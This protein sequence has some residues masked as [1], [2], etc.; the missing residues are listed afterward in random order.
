MRQANHA[1][2]ID[3]TSGRFR[4][5]TQVCLD[6]AYM[7]ARITS[8]CGAIYRKHEITQTQYHV[9]RI[10]AEAGEAGMPLIGVASQLPTRAA[11]NTRVIE[12]MRR[13]R[14]VRHWRLESDRRIVM[15]SLSGRGERMLKRIEPQLEQVY[16]EHLAHMEPEDLEVLADL[17]HAARTG[18]S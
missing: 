12:R 15:V 7:H 16:R 8:G 2:E 6:L 18:E 11:D 14:L 10:L 17:L 4:P 13:A 5:H 9:L 1:L 3:D